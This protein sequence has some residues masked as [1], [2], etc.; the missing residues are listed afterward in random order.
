MNT[1]PRGERSPGDAGDHGDANGVDCMVTDRTGLRDRQIG[2]PVASPRVGSTRREPTRM[3]VGCRRT[4][5]WS[6]LLR[7]AAVVGEDDD[8][9]SLVPDPAH[10]IP[11]RGAWLHPMSGCFE[12]AVRRK[13]FVRAL[14]LTSGSDTGLVVAYLDLNPHDVA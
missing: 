3:C 10:R 4:D 8:R 12:Q 14:R 13:A 6:A 1:R 5:S 9:V 11:G 2:A 7:V